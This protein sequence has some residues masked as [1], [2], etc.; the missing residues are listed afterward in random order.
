MKKVTEKFDTQGRLIERITETDDT[1]SAEYHQDVSKVTCTTNPK[2]KLDTPK[3]AK[4]AAGGI[5]YGTSPWAKDNSY[6]V[7]AHLRP[8]TLATL[9]S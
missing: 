9:H 1:A 4:L 2:T 8:P 7:P 3:L 6:V 5:V